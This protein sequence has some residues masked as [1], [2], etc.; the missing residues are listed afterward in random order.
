MKAHSLLIRSRVSGN[1]PY[2]HSRGGLVGASEKTDGPP[3]R[4]LLAPAKRGGLQRRSGQPVPTRCVLR[5]WEPWWRTAGLP[6]SPAPSSRR[7]CPI[8]PGTHHAI[9]CWCWCAHPRWCWH[10]PSAQRRRVPQLESAPS[11]GGAAG[12]EDAKRCRTPWSKVAPSPRGV[13]EQDETRVGSPAEGVTK[14]QR[15]QAGYLESD[16]SPL[17]RSTSQTES[18]A[19]HS[20]WPA[21]KCRHLI[22]TWRPTV[23]ELP[24]VQ[25]Q[26]TSRCREIRCTQTLLATLTSWSGRSWHTLL[27]SGSEGRQHLTICGL[28]CR[29]HGWALVASCAREHDGLGE[30]ARRQGGSCLRPTAHGGEWSVDDARLS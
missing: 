26:G 25:M 2:D 20:A 5:E 12:R 1:H 13:A 19:P 22:G 9:S 23:E 6:R 17:A 28:S 11:S 18:F 15:R 30:M 4:A 16:D 8:G 24:R 3:Q 10:W 21:A 29:P 7:G 27:W 14:A